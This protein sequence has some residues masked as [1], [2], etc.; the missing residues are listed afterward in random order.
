M[1]RLLRTSMSLPLAGLITL[2]LASFMT[3]LISVEGEPGPI[4]SEIDYELFP[5]VQ[6]I[7]PPERE[8]IEPVSR[9][10]PPP[11]PPA[12]EVQTASLPVDGGFAGTELPPIEGPII[13]GGS[14]NRSTVDAAAMAHVRIPP[15]YPVRALER[16]L[17]GYC[18]V[19]FDVGP[20]GTPINVR[21]EYCSNS[22]FARN[23]I[24]AVERWLYSPQIVNGAAVVQR[25]FRTQIT[26][27]L[28]E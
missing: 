16:G 17:E 8:T 11:P 22:V 12:I 25:D 15:D 7:N 21:T 20:D 13:Q 26:Y 27:S 19:H 24:R 18:M 1:Q 3:Y 2:S 5:D 14:I 4:V 28:N 9:V 23:S 10:D 6:I